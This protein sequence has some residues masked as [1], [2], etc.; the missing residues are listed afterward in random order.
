MPE[1]YPVQETVSS[2][3]SD[4]SLKTTIG[5]DA[6]LRLPIWH[7][8]TCEAL[9]MHVSTSTNAIKKW[10]TFKAHKEASEAYGSS[11]KQQSKQRP[12]WLF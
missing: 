1:K 5:E 2:L 10:G 4:Q 9:L 7:Y 6:E 12:L 11:A 3:K 8:G